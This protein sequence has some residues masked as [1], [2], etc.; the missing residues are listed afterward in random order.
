[1]KKSIKLPF[2]NILKGGDKKSFKILNNEQLNS[3]AGILNYIKKMIS[4]NKH[5][6]N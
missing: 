3:K 5:I 2:T 6:S 4:S 1:M